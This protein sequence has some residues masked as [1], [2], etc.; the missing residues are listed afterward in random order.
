MKKEYICPC[1][2]TFTCVIEMPLCVSGD[3]KTVSEGTTSGGEG[4]SGDPITGGDARTID[5]WEEE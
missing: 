4:G 2:A 3:G 1:T 5:V